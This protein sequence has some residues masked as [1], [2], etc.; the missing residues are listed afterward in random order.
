LYVLL[1]SDRILEKPSCEKVVKSKF[2]LPGGKARPTENI[3]TTAK[4]ITTVLLSIPEDRLLFGGYHTIVE[5]KPS[6]SYPGLKTVYRK[7]IVTAQ[8]V[9]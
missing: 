4:R 1:E 5:E 7:H 2:Q 3:Y 6:P 8:L 9:N